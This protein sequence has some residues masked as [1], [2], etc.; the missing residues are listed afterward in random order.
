MV[1]QAVTVL[2][3][4]QDYAFAKYS[5]PPHIHYFTSDQ[6]GQLLSKSENGWTEDETKYLL[7]MCEKYE[8]RFIVVQDRWNYGTSRSVEVGFSS[9]QLTSRI[10]KRDITKFNVY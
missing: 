2:L 8:L 3:I 6:Y 5:K 9:L 7:D 10:L 1:Q 4:T